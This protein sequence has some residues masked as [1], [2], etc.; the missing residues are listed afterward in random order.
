MLFLIKLLLPVPKSL[1]ISPDFSA[2]RTEFLYTIFITILNIS[3]HLTICNGT[4]MLVIHMHVKGSGQKT[5][6]KA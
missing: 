2:F 6:S 3:D 5:A 4:V 1:K